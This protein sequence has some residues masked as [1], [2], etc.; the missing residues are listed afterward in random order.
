MEDDDEVLKAVWPRHTQRAGTVFPE[1]GAVYGRM[2]L[3]L[4]SL[5]DRPKCPNAS[6]NNAK[7][8]AVSPGRWWKSTADDVQLCRVD[9]D[10]DYRSSSIYGQAMEAKGKNGKKDFL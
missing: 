1:G 4:T 3:F 10:R 7:C 8:D 5:D 6:R 9:D 2:K